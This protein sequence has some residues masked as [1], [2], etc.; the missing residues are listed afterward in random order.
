MRRFRATIV[1]V[2]KEM[3]FTQPVCVCVCVCVFAALG[4]QLAVR[5]R[6]IVICA[7]PR[8]TIFFP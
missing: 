2:V 3:S 5:V 6:H 8:S 4:D 7:L 1:V